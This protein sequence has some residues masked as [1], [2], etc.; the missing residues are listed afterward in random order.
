MT[1]RKMVCLVV[2]LST[3]AL[4][5]RCASTST[6]PP[7]SSSSSSGLRSR[8]STTLPTRYGN[9]LFILIFS[10]FSFT[11]SLSPCRSSAS[12][13]LSS[14]STRISFSSSRV[15][16]VT[17]STVLPSSSL[18]MPASPSSK[19]PSKSIAPRVYVS[20]PPPPP[21]PL[22][23]NLS[24]SLRRRLISLPSCHPTTPPTGGR[25]CFWCQ[26]SPCPPPSRPSPLPSCLPFL[27]FALSYLGS[28]KVALAVALALAQAVP[29]HM[30]C[31][32]IC[33]LGCT[34]T[35]GTGSGRH[36][37][38]SYRH[39]VRS[40]WSHLCHGI[41]GM[42]FRPGLTGSWNFSSSAQHPLRLKC[43]NSLTW[44]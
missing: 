8:I 34:A 10:M 26:L 30:M 4:P 14:R 1:G 5:C 13:L 3:T 37:G 32:T 42:V 27:A 21:P 23:L 31:K 20:P 15:R 19:T 2:V 22:D 35:P 44:L 40:H 33:H 41:P 28:R 39:T 7:S 16:M 29:S 43:L 6:V 11:F 25:F 17:S 18:S 36:S 12:R 24:Q 38:I 9:C